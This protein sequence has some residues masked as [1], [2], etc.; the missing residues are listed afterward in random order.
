VSTFD[1]IAVVWIPAA[2]AIV[3]GFAFFH[4]WLDDRAESRKAHH[5]AS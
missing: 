1:I 2:V 5:A 4:G 3:I